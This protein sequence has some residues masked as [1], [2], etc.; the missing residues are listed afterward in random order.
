MDSLCVGLSRVGHQ[1]A[2]DPPALLA[3]VCYGLTDVRVRA[4][5][6]RQ[7]T[8]SFFSSMP[9]GERRRGYDGFEG[10]LGNV[11]TRRARVGAFGSAQ[12]PECSPSACS[13]V[14]TN[15]LGRML[16]EWHAK[17]DPTL[18]AQHAPHLF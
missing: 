8:A 6:C 11:S 18:T 2:L 1:P 16:V 9:D 5:R 10:G 14:L 4:R 3:V 15:A 17:L 13:E 7:S 12:A